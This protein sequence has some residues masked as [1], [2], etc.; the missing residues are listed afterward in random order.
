MAG[1]WTPDSTPR[2]TPV[3]FAAALHFDLGSGDRGF[4]L[5]VW[6]NAFRVGDKFKESVAE[7]LFQAAIKESFPSRVPA[8]TSEAIG[9]ENAGN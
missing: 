4:G 1:T 6:K 7:S 5:G 3:H 8:L 2:G 9:Q